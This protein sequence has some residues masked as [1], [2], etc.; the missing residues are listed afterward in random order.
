LALA[1]NLKRN[2]VI[3]ATDTA[4]TSLEVRLYVLDSL[5]KDFEWVFYLKLAG[6]LLHAAIHKPF[7]KL[8][9]AIAHNTVDNALY[10][11]AVVHAVWFY[12]A[13]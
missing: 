10:L 1:L 3:C 8:F 2:L 4:R 12:I 5:L 9:F 7:S 13:Y 11:Y 6:R